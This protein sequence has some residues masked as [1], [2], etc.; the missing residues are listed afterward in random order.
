ME[1]AKNG[2]AADL[3]E[4]EKL[5]ESI[6]K[7]CAWVDATFDSRREKRKSEMDGLVEA[8][9]FLAGVEAGDD[10]ELE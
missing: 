1:E 8:K 2:K 6:E 3:A 9:N 7:D 4:E 10:S 5:K